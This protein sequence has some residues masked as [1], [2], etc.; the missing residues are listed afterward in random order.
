MSQHDV[1]L[2]L[3]SNLGDRKNNIKS[4]LSLIERDVGVII[5]KTELAITEPVEFDSNNF[6]CN[7]A[8]LIKTQFSPKKLLKLLKSIEREL[9]RETDTLIAGD[10]K[11]RIIDID[12]VL[13]DGLHF[14]S[15]DLEVPHIKH[16]YE[17]DFSKELLDL[18]I[19][20]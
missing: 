4:A 17:R 6:F 7:I 20:H 12:I 11:D 3:G 1:T 5:K 2:L 15:R 19:K 8:V 14:F 18:L 10:Y 16:L 9:G 13:Y